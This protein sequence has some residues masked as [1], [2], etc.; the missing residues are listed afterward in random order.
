MNNVLLPQRKILDEKYNRQNKKKRLSIKIFFVFVDNLYF[1]QCCKGKELKMSIKIG[2]S[3]I[4]R[5]E[6][7]ARAK[8]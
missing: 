5:V 1:I 6:E 7:L 4:Y 3:K 8:K 2:A